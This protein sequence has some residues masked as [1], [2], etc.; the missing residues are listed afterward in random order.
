MS[1][2]LSSLFHGLAMGIGFI[3]VFGFV[4]DANQWVYLLSFIAIAVGLLG[5]ESS[6]RHLVKE[7][8]KHE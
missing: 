1:E 7:I 2:H 3:G 4:I 6:L 5:L 8:Q